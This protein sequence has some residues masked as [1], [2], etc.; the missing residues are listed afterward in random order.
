MGWTEYQAT[1]FDKNGRISKRK[2]AIKEL[3]TDLLPRYEFV[4]GSM[5]NSAFYAAIRDKET[6]V[7]ACEVMLTGTRDN[8]WFS[9]KAIPERWRPTE[10]KCPDR[11]LDMLTPTDDEDTNIWRED[12]RAYN[13]AQRAPQSFKNLPEGTEATWEIP[14][15]FGP[16]EKGDV[17][18]LRKGRQN[19][20]K[21]RSRFVWRVV[22]W[23][24]YLTA[25]QVHGYE[26]IA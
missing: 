9:Y 1:E 15:S 25:G 10:T 4:D 23:G 6:G 26:V 21:Q 7:V 20:W 8:Y 2:E 13:R 22:G 11:I 24:Y 16:F 18:K 12:C 17:L 5:V 14:F 19:P 3:T